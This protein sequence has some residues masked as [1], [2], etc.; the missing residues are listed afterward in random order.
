V[1]RWNWPAIW[2]ILWPDL[3]IALAIVA[4]LLFIVLPWMARQGP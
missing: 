1:R 4:F 3:S 2:K